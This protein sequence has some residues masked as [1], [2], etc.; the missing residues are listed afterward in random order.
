MY[1]G[2]VKVKRNFEFNPH[3]LVQEF[4]EKLSQKI[5]VIYGPVENWKGICV[6]DN[7]G[8]NLLDQLPELRKLIAQ[9]GEDN[10]VAVFYYN[11]H[12]GSVQHT[13]RDLYGN[14]LFGCARLHVAL[15]TNDNAFLE[16]DHVKYHFG[17]GEIWSFDT[18]KVH[19]AI[20]VGNEDRIHIVMDVKKNS[21]TL[22]LFPQKNW[23]F[24]PHMIAFLFYAVRK[25][26]VG[27][28]KNKS[29]LS[30]NIKDALSIFQQKA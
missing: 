29:I 13:H 15:Q 14:G 26:F 9:I 11:L 24:Y 27:I 10:V 12:K 25:T 19:R 21:E 4:S 23:G 20:N 5:K 16:V 28:F 30:K 3:M 7:Q 1:K 8:V 22:D 6:K 17:I 18:S 2:I